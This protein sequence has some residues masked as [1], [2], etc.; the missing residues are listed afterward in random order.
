MTERPT[1][2]HVRRT[3]TIV[4]AA[5]LLLLAIAASFVLGSMLASTGY[6]ATK[7]PCGS[8][9]LCRA[10]AYRD[11]QV[12]VHLEQQLNIANG[13]AGGGRDLRKCHTLGSCRRIAS[14][15]KRSRAWAEKAWA[16]LKG[17]NSAAG[18]QRIIRVQFHPCGAVATSH[19]LATAYNE[20]RYVINQFASPTG[21]YGG[22]QINYFWHHAAFGDGSDRAFYH[23]ALSGWRSTEVAKRWSR[24]GRVFSSL[25]YG[26]KNYGIP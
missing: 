11:H 10:Y 12:V 24:C 26:A 16:H 17:D 4:A 8:I 7:K 5:W 3:Q 13:K 9:P 15:E 23:V 19:A 2:R 6:T 20:N 22:W 1:Q 25:W 21:D 18:F 14:Q